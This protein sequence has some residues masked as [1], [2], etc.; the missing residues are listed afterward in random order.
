MEQIRWKCAWWLGRMSYKLHPG[1]IREQ[2]AL[3]NLKDREAQE[4][5]LR[6]LLSDTGSAFQCPVHGP[7]TVV[8]C[9]RAAD[10]LKQHRPNYEPTGQHL[11]STAGKV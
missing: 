10:W 8:F 2:W 11:P 4:K 1:P 9:W 7:E 3:D 5:R 6:S